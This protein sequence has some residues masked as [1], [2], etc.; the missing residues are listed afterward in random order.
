[1]RTWSVERAVV[2]RCNA[3]ESSRAAGASS[4]HLLLK[5]FFYD[6]DGVKNAK[7]DVFAEHLVHL[8][9]KPGALHDVMTEGRRAAGRTCD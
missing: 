9:E 6:A 4:M 1:M 7:V 3:L 5:A 2:R 8:D